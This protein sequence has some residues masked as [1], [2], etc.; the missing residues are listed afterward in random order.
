MDLDGEERLV[1]VVGDQGLVDRAGLDAGGGEGVR[2][3][4]AV[5]ETGDT[6]ARKPRVLWQQEERRRL[7]SSSQSLLSLLLVLF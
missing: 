4:V 5:S 6:M 2:G 1:G 7:L 3:G